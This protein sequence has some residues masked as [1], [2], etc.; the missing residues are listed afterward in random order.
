[1][2]SMAFQLSLAL[3]IS[4]GADAQLYQLR[5]DGSISVFLGGPCAATACNGWIKLDAD[6]SAT[7]IASATSR[8]Y[9]LQQDG[10]I[11]RYTGPPCTDA[12]ACAGWMLIG[13]V[14]A[15]SR[16]VAGGNE[17]YVVTRAGDILWYT[18]RPCSGGSC[19]QRL[20]NEPGTLDVIAIERRL[21]QLVDDGRIYQYH[22]P[23]CAGCG[24]WV[25]RSNDPD[26]TAI[27]VSLGGL[28]R[29]DGREGEGASLWIATGVRCS[30]NV[31]PGWEQFD[32]R[33]TTYDIAAA[34]TY[35]FTSGRVY[36]STTD[37]RVLQWRNV[38][39]GPHC[40]NTDRWW[41]P[42]DDHGGRSQL[43]TTRD[44][45]Y[46]RR[47]DGTI[48]EY[49]SPPCRNGQCLGWRKIDSNAR[50]RKIVGSGD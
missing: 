34:R 48:W 49:I 3:V 29:F 9:K 45:L 46:Q 41:A 27:A 16:I 39:C 25:L 23:P 11:W 31:C 42:I 36:Q 33:T 18:G 50:R 12:G 32:A 43:F 10:D 20:N 17:L 13:T 40:V 5:D 35:G 22:L 26:T 47:T 44:K 15:A 28:Y 19:W 38:T 14:P 1:M 30:G 24:S 7:D 2:R 8:L 21:Y 37:G 4:L 6:P